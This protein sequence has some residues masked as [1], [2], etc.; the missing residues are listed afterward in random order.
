MRESCPSDCPCQYGVRIG[1]ASGV[2]GSE[3]GE[4][5]RLGL[6]RT[7]VALMRKNSTMPFSENEGHEFSENGG[8]EIFP[9]QCYPCLTCMLV[10]IAVAESIKNKSSRNQ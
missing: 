7:W 5:G 4:F 10:V 1:K 3:S 8:V 6:S 9:P 2:G